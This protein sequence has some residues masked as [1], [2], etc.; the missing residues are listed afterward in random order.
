MRPSLLLRG[1][2]LSLCCSLLAP[3]THAQSTFTPFLEGSK[4]QLEHSV[5]YY[6]TWIQTAYEAQDQ[7]RT[8]VGTLDILLKRNLELQHALEAKQQAVGELPADEVTQLQSLKAGAKG[9]QGQLQQSRDSLT[10]ATLELNTLIAEAIYPF[11][12]LPI[13]DTF[14][15]P[16]KVGGIVPPKAGLLITPTLEGSLPLETPKP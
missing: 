7:A 6:Q 12:I 5:R 1:L 10:K 11:K 3:L 14:R 9:L 15:F 13:T 4:E 2:L 8:A 16:T